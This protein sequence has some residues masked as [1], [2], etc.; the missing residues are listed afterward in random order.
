MFGNLTNGPNL[1]CEILE[2]YLTWQTRLGFDLY[3]EKKTI[4]HY[5][6]DLQWSGQEHKTKPEEND[7]VDRGRREKCDR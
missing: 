2:Y 6:V 3:V 5:I 1:I 4:L 7:N